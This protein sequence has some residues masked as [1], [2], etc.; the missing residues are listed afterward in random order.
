[1]C[2]L[3]HDRSLFSYSIF[4]SCLTICS[5]VGGRFQYLSDRTTPAPY[6]AVFEHGVGWSSLGGGIGFS[7]HVNSFAVFNNLLYIG[8]NFATNA[9]RN[10]TLNGLAVYDGQRLSN[11]T[12][13]GGVG[14]AQYYN[15]VNALAVYKSQLYIGGGFATL[16]DGTSA[17]RVIAYNGTHALPLANGTGNGMSGYAVQ[18]MAVFDDG[19]GAGEKLFIGG[20]FSKLGDGV[21]P[22]NSIAAFDGAEWS[23]LRSGDGNGV[24]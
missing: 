8:G 13:G 10:V 23:T 16:A 3:K 9:A 20:Y 11:V 5:Y 22:A 24:R 21:T 7:E 6:I 15:G 14:V 2:P 1:M 19:T 12:L 18:S 4:H 17:N